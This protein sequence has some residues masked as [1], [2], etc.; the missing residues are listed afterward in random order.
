MSTL[1][2]LAIPGKIT[3]VFILVV[4]IDCSKDT[5]F[6][7]EILDKI[8]AVLN[9]ASDPNVLMKAVGCMRLL[10]KHNSMF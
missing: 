5:F 9:T 2:N 3:P 1:R 10:S 6:Q 8:V 7:K 4:I